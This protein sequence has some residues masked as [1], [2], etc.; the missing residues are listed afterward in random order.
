[1]VEG[2]GVRPVIATYYEG[3]PVYDIC[4]PPHTGS[5][6]T[7][8]QALQFRTDYGTT[9]PGEFPGTAASELSRT[10]DTGQPWS[11]RSLG[12]RRLQCRMRA[13]VFAPSL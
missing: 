12:L 10:Q 6:S 1:M 11:H 9:A 7:T 13:W 5:T 2:A 3:G 4:P 8:V